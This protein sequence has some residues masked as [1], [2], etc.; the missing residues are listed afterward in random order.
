MNTSMSYSSAVTT[1]T[2]YMTKPSPEITETFKS[3][4][5]SFCLIISLTAFI[6]NAA[7]LFAVCRDPLRIFKTK[8]S[9]VFTLS[10]AAF[11]LLT[12]FVYT[13][14]YIANLTRSP[15]SSSVSLVFIV[16]FV[17]VKGQ[18]AFLTVLALAVDR[19]IAVVYAVRYKKIVTRRKLIIWTV[20]IWGYS[21]VFTT[22]VNILVQL[23]NRDP[24][25]EEIASYLHLASHIEIVLV[26]VAVAVLYF[27]SF[28][29]LRHHGQKLRGSCRVN[30]ERKQQYLKSE[31]QF[32]V[33]ILLT[34]I[35][36][37]CTVT[38]HTIYMIIKL[39]KG[40]CP[41]CKNNLDYQRF[42]KLSEG[43]YLLLF[44]ANPFV[45]AWRLPTFR[46]AL[47]LSVRKRS[48]RSVYY[49]RTDRPESMKEMTDKTGSIPRVNT[50]AK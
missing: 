25:L 27:V 24:I 43:I 2:S 4:A 12:G 29:S 16:D 30:V 48:R 14:W 26:L 38:P 1:G 21:F 45:Y 8:A 46:S 36:L 33:A 47:A 6:G 31:K 28:Q 19:Y 5:W 3:F 42:G 22:V 49:D 32:A 41:Q 50:I 39:S 23:K 40:L 15:I 10:L 44:A 18:C 7:L 20:I 37:A 34:I 17:H 9:S 11:D 13:V 35:I